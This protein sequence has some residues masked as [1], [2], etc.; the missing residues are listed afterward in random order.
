[1]IDA[2]SVTVT[3]TVGRTF[4]C[5]YDV[6]DVERIMSLFR[7]RVS[8]LECL[9]NVTVLFGWW[10]C[11]MRVSPV[12]RP[13]KR[14]TA[15]SGNQPH[16]RRTSTCTMLGCCLLGAELFLGHRCLALYA[17]AH[18]TRL[19]MTRFAR[20]HTA[21]ART[22]QRPRL[23]PAERRQPGWRRRSARRRRLRPNAS[24]RRR[25]PRPKR[26]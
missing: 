7:Q 10:G 20:A 1:M 26:R 18:D 3:S 23:W 4:C 9:A 22:H 14:A 5:N 17:C 24:A 21:H 12:E 6:C 8:G 19:R 13:S 15:G 2:A 11:V 16:T 25:S